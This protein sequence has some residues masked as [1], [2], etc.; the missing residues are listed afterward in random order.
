MTLVQDDGKPDLFLT[1]T[2]NPQWPETCDNLKHGQTTQDRPDL[3]SRVFRAKLEDIKEQLFN[4]HLLGEVKAYVYVIEF[5]KRCLPHAHFLLIMYPRDK[6]NNP[7]HYDKVVCAEIPDVRRHSKLHEL[8][9]KH[10]MHSPCGSLR[11]TALVYRE[12][13]N[14]VVSVILGNLMT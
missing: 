10:M 14:H 4:K 5:Q 3:V 12:I 7:D 8:V 1:V 13:L 11:P 2:C 9:V 6:I